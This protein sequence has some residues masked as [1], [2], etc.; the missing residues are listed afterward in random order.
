MVVGVKLPRYLMFWY[1][2]RREIMLPLLFPNQ[3]GKLSYLIS[4]ITNPKLWIYLLGPQLIILSLTVFSAWVTG[5]CNQ[6]IQCCKQNK[7]FPLFIWVIS[8]W[9]MLVLKEVGELTLILM[10]ISWDLSLGTRIAN[11]FTYSIGNNHLNLLTEPQM[12]EWV[13]N[14]WM[15]ILL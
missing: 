9:K 12:R 7:L 14:W 11:I 3:L 15:Q 13:S 6:T 1:Y 5:S 8:S 2:R 4:S 10:M